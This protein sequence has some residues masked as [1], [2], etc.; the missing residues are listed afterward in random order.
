MR[1][2]DPQLI[3]N[4]YKTIVD[5][6]WL[7]IPIATLVAM[8]LSVG[9]LARNLIAMRFCI[10]FVVILTVTFMLAYD[11][12]LPIRNVFNYG[13]RVALL[14]TQSYLVIGKLDGRDQLAS[15]LLP[16]HIVIAP[17]PRHSPDYLLAF[18][19]GRSDTTYRTMHFGIP[20][21]LPA[22][23]CNYYERENVIENPGT[24]EYVH[25]PDSLR[26]WVIACSRD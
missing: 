8:A 9:A 1:F 12:S 19:L 11:N 7:Y 23:W 2:I 21:D 25:A 3:I 18:E 5:V 13:N 6:V 26:S 17:K 10:G 22:Y 14:P 20:L 24:N 4:N 15:V 16:T